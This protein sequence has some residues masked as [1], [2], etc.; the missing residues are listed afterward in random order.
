M[1]IM[2][3]DIEHDVWLGDVEQD[4]F[5]GDVQQNEVDAACVPSPEAALV[6]ARYTGLTDRETFAICRFVNSSVANGN[7]ALMDEVFM[8]GLYAEANS[9]IG[10][11]DK[12]LTLK[13]GSTL[14]EAGIGL[15]FDGTNYYDTNFAPLTDG[16]ITKD[17]G[18]IGFIR[19]IRLSGSRTEIGESNNFKLDTEDDKGRYTWGANQT[20]DQSGNIALAKS[21]YTMV[22]IGGDGV[23]KYTYLNGVN[24]FT[25]GH[26]ATDFTANGFFLASRDGFGTNKYLGKLASTFIGQHI[27]LDYNSWYVDMIQCQ[28]ELE[29]GQAST[30]DYNVQ[31]KTYDWSNRELLEIQLDE[32]SQ[33]IVDNSDAITTGRSFDIT[34]NLGISAGAQAN[35]DIL[36]TNG[37]VIIQ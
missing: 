34:G 37:W 20:I 11:V 8:L 25:G 1:G 12:S 4:V 9:L 5:L 2:L 31:D 13:A 24:T 32:L 30:V 27:G 22:S 36:V 16:N 6:L 35:L 23:N 10:M 29:I 17:N 7:W 28:N 15:E 21:P 19:V 33:I 26:G 3:G 14:H 18:V